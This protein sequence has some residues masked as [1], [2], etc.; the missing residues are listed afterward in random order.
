MSDEYVC[1]MYGALMPEKHEEVEYIFQVFDDI[2][3]AW[4]D[5][6]RVLTSYNEVCIKEKDIKPPYRVVRK[7]IKTEVIA[8]HYKVE[9]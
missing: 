8:T 4:Y 9:S 3:D 2:D 1:A 5:F 6:G 7:I